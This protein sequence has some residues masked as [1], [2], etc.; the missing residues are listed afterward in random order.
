MKLKDQ[1]IAY[2]K[3]TNTIT[4]VHTGNKASVLSLPKSSV[5]AYEHMKLAA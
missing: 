1:T 5:V 2:D 4:I 3:T